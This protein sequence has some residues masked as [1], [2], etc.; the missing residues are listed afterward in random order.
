MAVRVGLSCR[1]DERQGPHA[2]IAVVWVVQ[3]PLLRQLL[4]LLDC[5]HVA[6]GAEAPAEQRDSFLGA[7]AELTRLER[8]SAP[9]ACLAAS[10]MS[11]VWM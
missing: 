8:S 1:V 5:P 7:R 9:A 6:V 4:E 11:S 2:G 10:S 3:G